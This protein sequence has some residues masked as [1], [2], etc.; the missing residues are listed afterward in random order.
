LLQT[1]A[2]A[3]VTTATQ[4]ISIGGGPSLPAFDLVAG[5]ATDEV[6]QSGLFPDSLTITL[7]DWGQSGQTN[8]FLIATI[9]LRGAVINP[10]SQGTIMA[11]PGEIVLAP[12]SD[13]SEVSGYAT[14]HSFDVRFSPPNQFAGEDAVLYFDLFDNQQP[15]GSAGWFSTVTAVPE[16]GPTSLLALAVV[17][18]W[19]R[20][21]ATRR[22]SPAARQPIV[23]S[24]AAEAPRSETM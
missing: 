15:P 23:R 22:R 17:T 12:T 3:S 14:K 18:W 2:G 11:M 21:L 16:P 7:Q 1:G 24:A 9:D 4:Q 6:P 13:P 5:F 19:C 10:A 20:R 8:T